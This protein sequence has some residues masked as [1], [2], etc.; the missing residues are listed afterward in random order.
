MAIFIRGNIPEF[1]EKLTDLGQNAQIFI[2]KVVS[3]KTCII[4]CNLCDDVEAAGDNAVGMLCFV[5]IALE[6]N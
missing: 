4:P 5:A 6:I 2:Q 1:E 3:F